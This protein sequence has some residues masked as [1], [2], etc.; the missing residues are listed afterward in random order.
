MEQQTPIMSW[1]KWENTEPNSFIYQVQRGRHGLNI[2]LSN[3]VQ[4]VNK[5]IYGTH[6]GRYY[7]IG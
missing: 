1:D 2:G 3:G 4:V 6:R 7:L 5:Y